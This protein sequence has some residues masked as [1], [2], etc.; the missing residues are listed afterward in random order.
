MGWS[1]DLGFSLSFL[2]NNMADSVQKFI[3]T[4]AFLCL[5]QSI[6]H[7]LIVFERKSGLPATHTAAIGACE[8]HFN[9]WGPT[10]NECL[11]I[12][13]QQCAENVVASHPQQVSPL[14]VLS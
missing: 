13:I 1:H 12:V 3:D 10:P 9:F 6:V 5:K 14:V 2:Y 4:D 11:R 7:F 8:A